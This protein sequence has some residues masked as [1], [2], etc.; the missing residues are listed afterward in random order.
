MDRPATLRIICDEHAALR[1]VLHA[2]SSIVTDARRRRRRPDFQA[3]RAMLFYVDEFPERLHHVKESR[4]L[5]PRLREAV[6]A[7]VLD[8]L[9]REHVQGGLRVRELEHQ[10]A[11]W[12]LLGEPRREVFEQA[13][14]RYVGFY[15]EHM[16][17]E[18]A[19]VLPL[20]ARVLGADDWRVLDR[21]FGLN[22]D[23]LTGAEPDAAYVGLFET[24]RR[25]LPALH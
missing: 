5:Y 12:E 7:P 25:H 8:R 20:A 9:D 10:L 13:L 3:L 18:E 22:R 19:E 11:A 15:L 6:R 24:L 14:Q 16:R 21:A 2:M 23:A 17:V 1:S 4:M